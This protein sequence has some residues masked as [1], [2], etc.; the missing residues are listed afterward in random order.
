SEY[1]T[2]GSAG[3]NVLGDHGGSA[4]SST[5][6]VSGGTISGGSLGLIVTGSRAT[7]SGGRISAN[8]ALEARTSTASITGGSIRGT[9]V[10]SGGSAVSLSGGGLQLSSTGFLT[11]TLQDGTPIATQT[12]G[13]WPGN[14]DNVSPPVVITCSPAIVVPSAAGRCGAQVWAIAT[15]HAGCSGVTLPV[16]GARADGQSLTDLYPVGTTAITWTATD[17]AGNRASC[18]QTVTVEDREKPVLTCPAAITTGT[19]P[20]QC[21]AAVN[22]GT[23][24]AQDNCPGAV[25]VSG[26]RSDGQPLTAP[27]PLG[28][29]TIT[30]SA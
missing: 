28:T 17:A 8:W 20:G 26:T 7:I 13:L 15:A 1:G 19:D 6:T 21:T 30:W 25:A 11:G 5:V 3:G 10:A 12:A 4:S 14:L 23:A 16:Q 27:Y 18:T 22:P 2:V 29:T 9:L 24:T